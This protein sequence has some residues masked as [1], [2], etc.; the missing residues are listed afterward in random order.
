MHLPWYGPVSTPLNFFSR[1][2]LSMNDTF[3]WTVEYYALTSWYGPLSA[4]L[5][6]FQ[7]FGTFNERQLTKDVQA[8]PVLLAR[9]EK[10]P[11]R[12]YKMH[13]TKNAKVLQ[14]TTHHKELY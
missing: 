5:K 4:I 9:C 3:V 10:W 2:V 7:S 14:A 8:V 11:A 6:F 12:V 13:L 1:L